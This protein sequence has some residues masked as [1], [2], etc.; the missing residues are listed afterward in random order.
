MHSVA[1]S[2]ALIIRSPF[3]GLTE[4]AAGMAASPIKPLNRGVPGSVSVPA[5]EVIE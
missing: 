3:R 1:V 4:L 2:R 5:D